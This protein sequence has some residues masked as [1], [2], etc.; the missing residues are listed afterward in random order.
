MCLGRYDRF[1]RKRSEGWTTCLHPE[2][3]RYFYHE[4]KRIFTD[5]NL[6]DSALFAFIEDDARKIHDFLQV[7][8]LQLVNDKIELVLDHYVYTNGSFAQARGR[9]FHRVRLQ[10]G[11]ETLA[12]LHSLPYA[13]LIWSKVAKAARCHVFLLRCNGGGRSAITVFLAAETNMGIAVYH[14]HS[15]SPSGFIP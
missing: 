13:M 14:R 12:I 11:L 2:S 9:M 1:R 5:A 10:L 8:D 7:Q 15:E 3:A 4:E 6:F